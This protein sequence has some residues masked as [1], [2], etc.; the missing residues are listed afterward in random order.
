[1]GASVADVL[2]LLSSN[3]VKLIAIAFLLSIPL[4][5]YLLNQWLSGFASRISITA[6]FF[7]IAGII[8]LVTA[9]LTIGI[10]SV[11]AALANP[12]DALKQE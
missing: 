3:F 11:R 8:T 12:V 4:T 6:W 2:V 9:M 7:V 5:V 1:V 10:Q